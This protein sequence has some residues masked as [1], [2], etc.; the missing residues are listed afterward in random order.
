M[1][2]TYAVGPAHLTAERYAERCF[3]RVSRYIGAPG[4]GRRR[5]TLNQDGAGWARYS[6]PSELLGSRPITPF[7]IYFETFFLE[8]MRLHALFL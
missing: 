7:S 1:K 6:R 8:S 4:D 2:H 5:V 3:L